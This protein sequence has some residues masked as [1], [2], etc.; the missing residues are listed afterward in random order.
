MAHSQNLLTNIVINAKTGSGFSEVGSVLAEMGSIVNGISQELISF[1]KDSVDVYKDYQKNMTEAEVALSTTYG[2]GTRELNTVMQ[3]LDKAA[4]EWSASTIF[5]TD[6][7]AEAISNAA[8]AGWDYEQIMSGI[9][10]AMELAQAGSLDLSDAVD[11]ITKATHAAGIEFDDL[12]DFV[13]HWTYAANRSSAGVD[14]MGEA[15]LRMGATMRMTGGTDELLVMLAE[16]ADAGT[17]GS[18]AGTLLRNAMLRLVSPTQ[19]ASDVMAELGAET[20]EIEEILNDEA[21]A[22]ANAKLETAGFSAYDDHGNLKSMLTIFEDLSAALDGMSEQDRNAILSSIFPT[23]SITGA[24]ALLD[25]A[26]EDWHGLYDDLTGGAAEG[27]GSWAMGMMDETLFG[28]IEHFESLVERLKQKTGESL[29]SDVENVLGDLGGFVDNL[30]NMDSGVFDALVS[31]LEIVAVSG[32]GIIAASTAL[33]F[34]GTVLSPGGAIALGATALA[35]LV[36]FI[37]ELSDANFESIFGEQTLDHDAISG[38]LDGLHSDFDAAMKLFDQY[39]AKIDAAIEKYKSA[40]SQLTSDLLTDMLTKKELTEED[41]SSLQSLGEQM[42]TE[43][44]AGINAGY[45]QAA[46]QAGFFSNEDT[47][48][49]LLQAIISGLTDS[50]EMAIG[51]AESIGENI[52]DALTRAFEEGVTPEIYAEV[53]GY[54]QELNEIIAT[55]ARDAAD[56]EE[57]SQRQRMLDRASELSE[58]EYSAELRRIKEQNE[59]HAEQFEADAYNVATKANWA[60]IKRLEELQQAYNETDDAYA[61]AMMAPDM[62]RLQKDIDYRKSGELA[63]AKQKDIEY[64]AESEEYIQDLYEGHLG[65]NAVVGGAFQD[66]QAAGRQFGTGQ[67]GYEQAQA[68]INQHASWIDSPIMQFLETV[69]GGNPLMDTARNMVH[70]ANDST[71]ALGAINRVQGEAIEAL[72]GLKGMEELIAYNESQGNTA[73]ADRL[74][75]LY[76]SSMAMN[77]Y[78]EQMSAEVPGWL[79]PVLGDV[80]SEASGYKKTDFETKVL[81]QGDDR[82][83]VHDMAEIVAD[84]IGRGNTVTEAIDQG[85]HSITEQQQADFS[86]L[87]S[88]LSSQYD[89]AAAGEGNEEYGALRLAAGELDGADF[90]L[91]VPVTPVLDPDAMIDVEPLIVDV[92]PNM[93][94]EDVAASV[95]DE[96]VVVDVT[97]ETGQLSESISAEDGQTLT[98]LVNGDASDLHVKIWN[99]DSQ[100]LTEYAVGDVSQLAAAINSQ[101]GR[102]IQVIVDQVQGSTV[103]PMKTNAFGGRAT[104]PEIFG[105]AGP[106]W[107]I[108][109]AHTD[110]TAELLNAARAASGFTW[111]ELLSKFGGLNGNPNNVP[112]SVVYSP[113]IHA[114]DASGV[115]QVLKEDKERFLRIIEEHERQQRLLNSIEMYN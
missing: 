61:R 43:V 62:Y 53:Q 60:D 69:T 109:E 55:A 19:K 106:E 31:G 77:G 71:S 15:M 99:E 40:S 37:R 63:A 12:G 80:I 81:P 57:Y 32:P 18:D 29:A 35:G 47:N 4:S 98:E 115:D 88:T 45:D 103:T 51:E 91:E 76:G 111:P 14:G 59:A 96:A 89:L 66:V 82:A 108:P 46:D 65:G 90:A 28:K 107:A 26:K 10:A 75:G 52:R 9:P 104:S 23:R 84:S 64:R 70:Y 78:Q 92:Q 7:V 73:E 97:G 5:H 85:V 58:E 44:K 74:R 94:E 112:T 25:A 83:Y 95:S 27:Y 1:G 36:S 6:D 38:Y 2:R 8:H 87:V 34:L 42:V 56:Q 68:D 113:V 72:G 33:R 110:R 48:D 30:N 93:S 101:N 67:I 16:L 22:A 13:D 24:L 11:Y 3:G 54:V 50:S 114:A 102:H 39:D 17:V 21:V 20:S 41:V 105:E 79:K 49:P 86:N 100:T